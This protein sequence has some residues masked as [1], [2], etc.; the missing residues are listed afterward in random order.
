MEKLESVKMEII[1]AVEQNL[2]AISYNI[3]DNIL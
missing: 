3:T 1:I 2:I